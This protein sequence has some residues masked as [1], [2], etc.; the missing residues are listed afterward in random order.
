MSLISRLEAL[1]AL[2]FQNRLVVVSVP[3]ESTDTEREA[4]AS[5]KYRQ[6]GM[7]PRNGD[8]VVYVLRFSNPDIQAHAA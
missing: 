8:L 5:A 2:R 6:D 4:L 7:T 1:E 3:A